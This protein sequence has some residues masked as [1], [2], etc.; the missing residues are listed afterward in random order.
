MTGLQQMLS[1]TH[2]RDGYAY[3][4]I[5]FKMIRPTPLWSKTF[6]I[7]AIYFQNIQNWK[8]FLKQEW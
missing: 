2:Y 6:A 5:L 8:H 3:L 4:L 1:T 7:A